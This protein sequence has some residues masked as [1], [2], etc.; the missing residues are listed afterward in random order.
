MGVTPIKTLSEFHDIIN[1]QG[2]TIIVNFWATWCGPCR[3]IAP[4]FEQLSGQPGIDF[5]KIDVDIAPDVALEVGIRKTPTF[6]L[7]KDGRK[8]STVTGADFPRLEELVRQ[9]QGPK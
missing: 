1:S 4:T 5:Y 9:A 2:K 6:I 7:Y 3:N 8:V